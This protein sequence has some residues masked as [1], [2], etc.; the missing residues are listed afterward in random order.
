VILASAIRKD[1]IVYVGRRHHLIMHS[2]YN[3]PG[4]L[5]LGEQGFITT[6]G[7]FLDRKQGANHAL[8]CGQITELKYNPT[9]LFSEDLW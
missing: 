9:D 3:P 6:D 5:K 8:T 4:F 7:V 1:G 2:K